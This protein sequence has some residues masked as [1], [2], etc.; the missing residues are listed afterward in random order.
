MIDN[1]DQTDPLLCKLK[2]S[3]PLA[4]RATPADEAS[5][6]KAIAGFSVQSFIF[7]ASGAPLRRL[8][9]AGFAAVL[10]KAIGFYRTKA[11]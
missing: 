7:L 9:Q 6:D 4:A 10:S 2:E 1:L 11:R 3:L 8:C 5:S